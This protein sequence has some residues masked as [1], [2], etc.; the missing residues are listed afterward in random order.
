ML[1][2]LRQ[3]PCTPRKP[4]TRSGS[5]IATY[6]SHLLI[7]GK[8]CLLHNILIIC[9]LISLRCQMTYLPQKDL[10]ASRAR[11]SN[12]LWVCRKYQKTVRSNVCQRGS[13]VQSTGH[14]AV[15]VQKKIK[16]EWPKANYFSL[17]EGISSQR[18][19]RQVVCGLVMNVASVGS[20]EGCDPVM[21]PKPGA[22]PHTIT[23]SLT[24]TC[25]HL[26]GFLKKKKRERENTSKW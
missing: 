2:S 22:G 26:D 19:T 1:G 23:S 15:K 9:I 21:G 14:D 6:E 24:S 5:W 13:W 17:I 11:G 16:L 20:V 10:H 25:S 18:V 4:D 12:L 3:L 7:R 8:V